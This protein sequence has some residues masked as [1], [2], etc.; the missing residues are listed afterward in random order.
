MSLREVIIRNPG[1]AIHPLEWT[2]CHLD[3]LYCR[4]QDAIAPPETKTLVHREDYIEQLKDLLDVY[5]WRS[6][7]FIDLF[8]DEGSPFKHM[9]YVQPSSLPMLLCPC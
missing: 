9:K 7:L 6:E 8:T 2:T 3:L 5:C 4:F 1:F